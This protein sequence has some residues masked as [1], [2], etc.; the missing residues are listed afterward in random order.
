M[1]ASLLSPCNFLNLKV[2]YDPEEA[3]MDWRSFYLYIYFSPLPLF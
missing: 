3:A 1:I 2:I